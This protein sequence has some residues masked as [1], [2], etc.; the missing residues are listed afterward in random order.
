M[1]KLFEYELNKRQVLER[2]G[3][4]T[5]IAGV[6]RYRLEEGRKDSVLA[7]DMKNGSG[8]NI[9]VL[10]GRAMDIADASYKGIP[11]AFMSKAGIASASYYEEPGLR[12][13][14]NYFGG[15]LTTCGLTYAGAPCVDNGEP[16]GLHGRISNIPADEVCSYGEWVGDEYFIKVSGKS[17]Q[18]C[19]FGENLSMTRQITMKMGENKI[20]L[21]D[22]IENLGFEQQPFMVIYHMN[23]GFPLVDE[24]TKLYVTSN[25]IQGA[26][27]HANKSINSHNLMGSPVN[28]IEEAVYFHK[29]YG[30]NEGLGHC[31]LV[32]NRL[33]IGVSLS[34]NLDELPNLTEWKMMGQGDYVVGM[35]PCNCKTLGRANERENGT[36][37]FIQPGEIKHIHIIV[38]VLEGKNAIEK[39]LELFK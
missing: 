25:C 9:T 35:E 15:L 38:E 22:T 1:A 12:W 23:F 19:M 7:I 26:T 3:N 17:T 34:F 39:N 33:N 11:L 24:G 10:P 6:K 4:I 18:S 13:L 32:N 21:D 2:V 14:R 30:D 31:T 8:I 20:F 37:R 36:L 16:L 28:G 5:Q 27:E 29:C